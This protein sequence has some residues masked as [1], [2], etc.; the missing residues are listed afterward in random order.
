MSTRLSERP[1][2]RSVKC[3]SSLPVVPAAERATGIT[4][5]GTR[6]TSPPFVCVS[7]TKPS[8]SRKSLGGRRRKSICRE[9]V[10]VLA[11][12]WLTE[13]E[14][15]WDSMMLPSSSVGVRNASEIAKVFIEVPLFRTC[16]SKVYVFTAVRSLS[17]TA[18]VALPGTTTEETSAAT[19]TRTRPA[20]IRATG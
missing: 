19:S 13:I 14:A 5:N 15:G 12:P 17:R 7:V 8:Y 10:K 16:R 4:W 1:R 2:L 6:R 20:P 9:R 3:E 11:R 18:K